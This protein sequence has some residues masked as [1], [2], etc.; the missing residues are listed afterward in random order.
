M[1]N[2]AI[3]PQHTIVFEVKSGKIH[4]KS[5]FLIFGSAGELF[6]YLGLPLFSTI[7]T[8]KWTLSG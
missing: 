4:K 7:R 5:R 6:H 2:C 8:I 3:F 1:E